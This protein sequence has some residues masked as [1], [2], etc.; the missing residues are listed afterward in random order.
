MTDEYY[1]FTR[2]NTD[3][4]RDYW[5]VYAQKPLKRNL[6]EIAC[7]LNDPEPVQPYR[8]PSYEASDPCIAEIAP[9]YVGQT[10]VLTNYDNM[11]S[12]VLG[13]DPGIGDMAVGCTFLVR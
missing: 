6:Q 11:A 4:K 3:L 9:L 12:Q 8:G 7:P 1:G 5:G 10:T 13:L 2:Y